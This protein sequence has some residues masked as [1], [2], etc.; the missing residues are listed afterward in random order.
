MTSAWPQSVP[1]QNPKK[2]HKKLKIICGIL[3]VL[4]VLI[5]AGIRFLPTIQQMTT[6]STLKAS[7]VSLWLPESPPLKFAP[8]RL[9]KHTPGYVSFE[10]VNGFNI[11]EWQAAQPDQTPQCGPVYP[12]S[13]G[14]SLSKT[15]ELAGTMASGQKINRDDTGTLFVTMDSTTV[16]IYPAGDLG[17]TQIQSDLLKY[18]QLFHRVTPSDAT[19]KLSNTKQKLNNIL[20]HQ[21]QYLS[22][23][24]L[25]PSKVPAGFKQTEFYIQGLKDP[26]Q[27][28]LQLTYHGIINGQPI[29]ETVTVD[30]GPLRHTFNPPNACGG[31]SNS[32]ESDNPPCG[33]TAIF[34]GKPVYASTPYPET[35]WYFTYYQSDN[36]LVVIQ[37]QI[38]G[39]GTQIVQSLVPATE[40]MLKQARPLNY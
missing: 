3:I 32:N 4:V 21:A 40:A 39:L 14:L 31:L 25:L 24:P 29:G 2:K 34:N 18:L 7:H 6:T 16:V 20:A 17:D 27:P 11:Y 13:S 35:G 28:S 23:K 1:S 10:L 5:F 8:N 22:Y 38:P 36:C 12:D 37:A 9:E 26:T 15:C 19:Q 33:Q 30:I